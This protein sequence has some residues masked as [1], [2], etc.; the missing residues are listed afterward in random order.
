MFSD[1]TRSERCLATP[2]ARIALAL[3]IGMALAAT[4]RAETPDERASRIFQSIRWQDGPCT[5]NLGTVAELEVPRGYRFT[6]REGA[7]LWDELTENPPDEQSVGVLV[8]DEVRW[9]LCFG[10]SDIGYVP[11]DEKDNLDANALLQSIRGNTEQGNAYRRQHGWSELH[12]VGW[13]HK[14]AY[15]ALT[16]NL[17]WAIRG[18][19]DEDSVNYDTRILGR[20]GVMSVKL[21]DSPEAF[22]STIPVV[23]EILTGFRFKPGQTYAEWRKG[24]RVAAFG[25]GALILGGGTAIA[26][27]TGLLAKLGVLILKTWKL[28]AVGFVVF[29]AWLKRTLFMS[30]SSAEK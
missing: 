22:E 25:L 9:A 23:K 1:R 17:V 14:P 3:V 11:D 21:V 5:V 28:V 13:E 18:R 16:H 30:G 19:S 15:D 8:P 4:A 26:A 12:I 6:D 10:Y 27:K 29:F 2:T 7:R 24:D 20:N